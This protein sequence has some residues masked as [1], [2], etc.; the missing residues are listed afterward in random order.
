MKTKTKRTRKPKPANQEHNIVWVDFDDENRQLRDIRSN[1]KGGL[2]FF[3]DRDE[4]LDFFRGWPTPLPKSLKP[5]QIQNIAKS[6]MHKG[7]YSVYTTD[8]GCWGATLLRRK[9]TVEEQNIFDPPAPAKPK[10]T[11]AQRRA[12]KEN[13]Q[14]GGRPIKWDVIS[15]VDDVIEKLK[16][17][18]ELGLKQACKLRCKDNKLPVNGRGLERHVRKDIRYK[19]WK[20]R[21]K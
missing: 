4:V 19:T 3:M 5:N 20:R 10:C 2:L 11:P 16:S 21:K 8:G 15:A 13:A 9:Y 6:Q 18:P 14:T 12:N 17:R 7:I 1:K